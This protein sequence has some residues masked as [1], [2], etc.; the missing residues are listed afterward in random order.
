MS[1]IDEI[2]NKKKTQSCPSKPSCKRSHPDTV[3][4]PSKPTKRKKTMRPKKTPSAH[5]GDDERFKDSR[6]TSH[7]SKTEEG[8]VIYREDELGIS[9][10]GGDTPLCPFDCNC[11]F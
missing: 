10:E 3:E 2:F 1:E 4:S 9:N 7:R 6:G 5:G 8:Y 11:C